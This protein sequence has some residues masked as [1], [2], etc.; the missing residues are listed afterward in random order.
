MRNPRAN[1]AVV[2][3]LGG[4]N[5]RTANTLNIGVGR[6]RM[7]E[8]LDRNRVATVGAAEVYFHRPTPRT[9]GMVELPSLFNPYWEARLVEPSLAQRVA[10]RAL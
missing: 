1:V 6:L 7:T 5:L 10:A 8:N 9:D 4:E 3:S 2:V